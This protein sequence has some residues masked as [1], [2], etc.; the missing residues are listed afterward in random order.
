MFKNSDFSA[1]IIYQIVTDRFYDGDSS[2]NMLRR[3]FDKTDPRKYHGGDWT[4]IVKKIKDGYLTGMG[5]SAVWISS[6]VEN[7]SG[8]D[9]SNG[10]AAYHGY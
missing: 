5:V 3:S 1:G 6:P 8:I 9:P 2:N 7:I 4:G 10:S